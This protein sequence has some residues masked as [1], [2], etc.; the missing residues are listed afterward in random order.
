[1]NVQFE[2]FKCAKMKNDVIK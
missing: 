2:A 1:M